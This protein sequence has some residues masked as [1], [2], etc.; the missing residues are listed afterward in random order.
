MG[1]YVRKIF[2]TELGM[3]EN[4]AVKCDTLEDFGGGHPDP[5]LTYAKELVELMNTGEYDLGAAFDGDGVS[6]G[7]VDVED[8]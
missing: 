7:V 8:G 2:C 6:I 1:P 3:P 4:N 5:N